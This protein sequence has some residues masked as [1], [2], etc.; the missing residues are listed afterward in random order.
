MISVFH[1]QCKSFVYSWNIYGFFA[2]F[3]ALLGALVMI[4]HVSYQYS[5]VEYLLSYLTIVLSLLLPLLTAFVF[6]EERSAGVGRFLRSLPLSDRDI[7]LGKYCALLTLLGGL[8]FLLL[9]LPIFLGLWGMVYY[10]SAY[11]AIFCFFL[12]GFAMLSV[13]FFLALCFKNHWI[14]FSVSYGVTIV[15]IALGYL[16][17]YLPGI[18]SVAAEHLSLFAAFAP[19][20][21]GIVDLGTVGL[22]LSVGVLF[23]LLTLWYSSKLWK[24]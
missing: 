3:F 1:R 18:W 22:Y 23:L 15:L 7:V 21:F 5:N 17:S 24:E 11:M 4:F 20:V 6:K 16:S 2:A 8:S 14:A 12:F 19:F 13:D 9:L 10:A